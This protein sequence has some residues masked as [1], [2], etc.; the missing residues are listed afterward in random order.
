MGMVYVSANGDGV[1][2]Q[3]G[4]AI[5]SDD[6]KTLSGLSKKFKDAHSNIEKWVEKKG[7]EIVASAGD[8]IIFSMPEEALAELESVRERYAKS[9][10]ATLTMGVGQTI[11]Q[12]SKALIY[13]KLNEKNQIVEYEPQMDDYISEED[14]EES[15]LP[16]PEELESASSEKDRAE[17]GV[18]SEDMEDEDEDE[19]EDDAEDEDE[20]EESEPQEI[21]ED[22]ESEEPEEDGSQ[23]TEDVAVPKDQ[24][25][26]DYGSEDME[27]GQPEHEKDMDEHE[28][29]IH[30]AQENRDDEADD[31]IIEADEE[32]EAFGDRAESDD[33]ESE[34]E[35]SDVFQDESE[36]EESEDKE[37]SEIPEFSDEDIPEDEDEESEDES[38]VPELSEDDLANFQDQDGSEEFEEES[39][40]EPEDAN[41]FLGDMMHSNL[42]ESSENQEDQSPQSGELKQKIFAALQS[43]KQNKQV[44]D[45]M[46][47]QNPDLYQGII[48]NIQSMIEMGKKLGMEPQEEGMEDSELDQEQQNPYGAYEQEVPVKKPQHAFQKSEEDSEYHVYQEDMD[49]PEKMN[50]RRMLEYGQNISSSNH[51]APHKKVKHIHHAIANAKWAGD[52][53]EIKSKRDVP[54]KK[55]QGSL[56]A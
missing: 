25:D 48:D 6:H 7:G 24:L 43:I 37:E 16:S 31:D 1:G 49:K 51:D 19:F 44:L 22:L 17:E 23:E 13:G 20:E 10:G 34:D 15:E 46:K 21:E 11:S 36:D 32:P 26:G 28:E 3:I 27:E 50:H 12:A 39:E 47:L 38:E 9:S 18:D 2:E 41:N 45:Q 42:E 5:L 56:R 52:T 8:E 29:F 14:E 54:V 40:E 35:D 55:P 4:N 33:E 53:V 30:D